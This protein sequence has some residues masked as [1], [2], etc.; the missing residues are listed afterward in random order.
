[1]DF[2]EGRK[3]IG[4]DMKVGEEIRVGLD[5]EGQENSLQK[6]KYPLSFSFN[7]LV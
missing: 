7:S 5:G 1:M 6:G 4:K 2:N 3:K